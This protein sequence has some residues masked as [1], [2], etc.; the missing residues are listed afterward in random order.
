[1][2]DPGI[3]LDSNNSARTWTM[4]NADVFEDVPEDIFGIAFQQDYLG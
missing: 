4:Y 1:M 3:T 2:M